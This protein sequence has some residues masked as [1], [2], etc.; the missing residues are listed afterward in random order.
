M[1]PFLRFDFQFTSFWVGFLAGTL[2]WLVVSVI[3]SQWPH[4]R[5]FLRDQAHAMRE[6][7]TAS[8]ETR[9]RNDIV[10]NI[11]VMHLAAPLFPLDE[12]VLEPHVLPVPPPPTDEET[13]S[14][15]YTQ[16]LPYIPDWPEL[17]AAF[18]APTRSLPEALRGG[19]NLILLGYPGTGKTVALAYLAG[20]IARGNTEFGELAESIPV[21]LHAADIPLSAAENRT[22]LGIL[23]DAVSST[24]STLTLSR[25]PNLLENTLNS[26]KI[27]ILIDGLDEIPPAQSRQVARWMSA[28]MRDYP[29]A[30]WVVAASP[31]DYAGLNQLGLI[32]LTLAVWNTNERTA[33]V[34]KWQESWLRTMIPAGQAETARTQTLLINNWLMVADIALNPLEFTLKVW[35]GY[36][37]DILGPDALKTVEAHLR[38]LTVGIPD[39]RPALEALAQQ[40]VITINPF[41]LKQEAENWMAAFESVVGPTS[42]TDQADGTATKTSIASSRILPQLLNAGLLVNHTEGRVG[43]AH[44]VLMGYLAGSAL[45]KTGVEHLANMPDWSGKSL[46]FTYAAAF[47]DLS[48]QVNGLLASK[49]DPLQRDTLL[50]LRWLRLAP[51]SVPWRAAAL[52]SLV[53]LLQKE[54]FSL[55][56]GVRALTALA[57]SGEAGLT[58]MFRQW[59]HSDN[60]LLR[61]LAI[62]GCGL[63]NDSKATNDLVAQMQ[64]EDI[65]IL[66]QSACLS[67]SII[68]DKAAR[69]ALIGGL[70]HGSEAIRDAAAEILAFD[71]EEGAQILQEASQVDDLLVRRAAVH[72]LG[73]VQQ[74]WATELLEKI[75]VEDAQ[76]LV[77][78]AATQALDERKKP[79][80]HTVQPLPALHQ[81]P[82]LIAYA[83]EQGMGISPGKPAQEMLSKAL[84]EGSDSQKLYALEYLRL[85]GTQENIV[86]LYNLFYSS[87]GELLEATY[88]TLWHISASGVTLPPPT[89]FGLG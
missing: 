61:Y 86:Q 59:L 46:A 88:N 74:P 80:T 1:P 7:L 50:P 58:V 34:S 42:S 82:W 41:C 5:Q 49:A 62:L 72:G 20:S 65:P 43:F 29:A 68:H 48:A 15:V 12:I 52:R 21:L 66:G 69:D 39:A 22:S 81:I 38:R 75:A 64:E 6:S 85:R 89:Q 4:F 17:P 26:G 25:L 73:C 10:R 30:R 67:L 45:A 79:G 40:M 31:D 16:A 23:I 78:S 11:Q 71:P 19:A 28:L 3:R 9:L 87:E 27:I 2:F 56:F 14:G 57:L 51:K 77:R 8:T 24:V 44:P 35:A 36:A 83:A 47:G 13:D 33:F 55:N 76:W 84:K 70:L 18:N 60:I 37:G 53:T 63:L 54:T 32:P